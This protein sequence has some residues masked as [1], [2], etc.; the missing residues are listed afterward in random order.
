VGPLYLFENL[1]LCDVTFQHK[2]AV[3]TL[4][5]WDKQLENI[6]LVK[7]A[8]TADALKKGQAHKK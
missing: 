7:T 5:F 8:E 3:L 1:E 6:S 4:S 2:Q